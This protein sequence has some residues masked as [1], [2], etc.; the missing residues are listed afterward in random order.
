MRFFRG[1]N[2]TTWQISSYAERGRA[3]RGNVVAEADVFLA[4]L[5][6]RNHGCFMILLSMSEDTLVKSSSVDDHF[7]AHRNI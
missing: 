7:A 5:S 6:N 3:V 4:F 1:F 2:P